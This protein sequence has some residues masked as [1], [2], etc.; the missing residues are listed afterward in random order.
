[1]ILHLYKVGLVSLAAVVVSLGWGTAKA[2]AQTAF[3]TFEFKTS[4]K[5]AV[6]INPFNQEGMVRATITGENSDAPYG[7][8]FFTSNTYGLL[9]PVT[10]PAIAKY[11]FNSDPGT[12]GLTGEPVFFDRYYGGANELF[13]KANDSAE[14]NFE[15]GTIKGGGTITIFDGTGIF[16]GATGTIT[17]T[18]E[19]R[20]APP[21]APSQG[22][23]VLSYSLRVPRA[24]PEPGTNASLIGLGVIGGGLVL[25]RRLQGIA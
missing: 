10:N 2:N 20:L 21:G 7:L 9:Q 18:Q 16:Q 25:R 12:F 4:Y 6:E 17:F 5:T 1:M 19:D 24:V 8:N 3:E 13:G 15:T 22:E 14:I 11:N 23:A